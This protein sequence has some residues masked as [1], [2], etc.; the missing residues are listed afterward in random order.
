MLGEA[1]AGVPD[2][3]GD[4]VVP[5][6]GEREEY[7]GRDENGHPEEAAVEVE[8]LIADGSE[9]PLDAAPSVVGLSPAGA[10]AGETFPVV[11]VVGAFDG[12]GLAAAA[13]LALDARGRGDGVR[14]PHGGWGATTATRSAPV[15]PLRWARTRFT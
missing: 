2:V 8:G 13:R 10:L 14:L 12:D 3:P 5:D 9:E 1:A 15:G 7:A 4:E 11:L 6:E